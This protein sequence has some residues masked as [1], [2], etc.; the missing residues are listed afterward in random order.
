MNST[1]LLPDNVVDMTDE[2]IDSYNMNTFHFSDSDLVYIC[3][4][5]RRFVSYECSYSNKKNNLHC[6]ACLETLAKEKQQPFIS[7]I[8]EFIWS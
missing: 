1:N 2:E 3:K 7:F 8:S 5:C 6:S 4:K